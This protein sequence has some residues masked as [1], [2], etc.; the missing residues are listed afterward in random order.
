MQKWL[1]IGDRV[2]IVCCS[3]GLPPDYKPKVNRLQKILRDIG[4]VP[5]CSDHIYENSAV[6]SGTGKERAASL[7]SFFGDSKIKAIFDISGGDIANELLPYLDYE[8]IAE[9]EAQ[10]WG[11]SDLTTIINAVYAKSGRVSILYSINNLIRA[12]SE[13]QIKSFTNS[14]LTGTD[15]LFNINYTILQGKSAKGIVVG[16]NIRCM[17]KLAGTQYWPDMTGKIL[18]LEA[19]SGSVAQLTA[20][21]S[22]LEQLGAFKKINGILLGTFTQLEREGNSSMITD[23]IQSYTRESITI[24]KTQE[25]GHA[26]DSKAI[27]IGGNIILNSNR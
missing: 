16:G 4:L 6:F 12:N 8:I 3:N 10:F 20:Y 19:N 17:L 21:L 5:H 13:Y 1:K 18:L 26:A 25:I 24:A 14:V 22:Q 9:S 23:L 15:D 2:A 7:M 11:Y 27:E